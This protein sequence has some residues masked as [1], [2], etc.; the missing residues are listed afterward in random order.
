MLP[1]EWVTVN[2]GI[3]RARDW[4]KDTLKEVTSVRYCPEKTGYLCNA[5]SFIIFHRKKWGVFLPVFPFIKKGG[6]FRRPP[7]DTVL[8]G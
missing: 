4:K 7:F 2:F 1:H 6:A 5:D 8:S 3:A